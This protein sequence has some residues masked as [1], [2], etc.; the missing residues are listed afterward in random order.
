MLLVV[1]LLA[2]G[3]SDGDEPIDAAGQ[4]IGQATIDASAGSTT[5]LPGTASTTGVAV[6]VD[7]GA[8]STDAAGG[9]GP[10]TTMT[11]LEASGSTE[12]NGTDTTP[13]SGPDATTAPST[14]STS[15]PSTAATSTPNPGNGG[16]SGRFATLP[17]G[18]DLPGG[19]DCAARVRATP[20]VRAAN[21]PYNSTRGTGSHDLYPRVDGAFTGTTDEIIQWAACKWGIDEDLARAQVAIESWWD[22]RNAGDM[23]TDQSHCHPEFRTGSGECAESIGL[24]QVRFL[25]HGD[26]FEDANAIRSS[27]YNLDYAFAIWRECYEGRLGWLND[28]DKGAEYRGGDVE[29]CLGVWFSGRWYTDAAVGYIARV[30]DYLARRVW[31]T[32]EFK[33]YG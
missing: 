22:M 12:T 20:E 13:T 11:G 9:T 19:A 6:T 15:S 7:T 21:V 14:E 17:P 16:G 4:E 8:T 2:A 30:D 32:S 24:M 28:V 29:G 1:A 33:S 5:T 25:Y 23:T 10:T 27:A 26:A 31:E 3:C 18:S